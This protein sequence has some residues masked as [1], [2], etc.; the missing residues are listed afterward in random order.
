MTVKNDLV[1]IELPKGGYVPTF[2]KREFPVDHELRIEPQLEGPLGAWSSRSRQ[3]LYRGHSYRWRY[4]VIGGGIV[5][6]LATVGIIW[7]L[8]SPP[9]QRP[10]GG[11]F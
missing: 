11:L 3:P 4:V 5:L 9:S 6:A 7:W 1:L 8:T 2:N 10:C